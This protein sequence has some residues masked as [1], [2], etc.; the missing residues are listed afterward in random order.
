MDNKKLE[1]FAASARRQLIS[2]ELVPRSTEYCCETLVLVLRLRRLISNLEARHRESC[3]GDK[4][5]NRVIEEQAYSW[6]NRI[7]AFRFMDANRY[8]TIPVVSPEVGFVGQP[9]VM[10]A[11][12]R[13]EFEKEVFKNSVTKNRIEGLLNGSVTSCAPQAEAYGLILKNTV[14]TE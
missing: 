3:G 8:T 14:A 4:G 13:G 7:I 1:T 11:A 9:A 12:K 5:I 10:A 2:E 6:F